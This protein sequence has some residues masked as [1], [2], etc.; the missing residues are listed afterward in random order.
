MRAHLTAALAVTLLATPAAASD[1]RTDIFFPEIAQ[2]TADAV[3]IT[4]SDET[5]GECKA[6]VSESRDVMELALR[7]AGVD[8]TDNTVFEVSIKVSAEPVPN[9]SPAALMNMGG[10]CRVQIV[11]LGTMVHTVDFMIS[12]E[13]IAGKF[14]YY[15]VVEGGVVGSKDIRTYVRDKTSAVSEDYVRKYQNAKVR[16]EG[17]FTDKLGHFGSFVSSIQSVF[18][19][20]K[21][22]RP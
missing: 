8:V 3:S 6:R 15:M 14:P 2:G 10:M 4:T 7:R 18:Q 22:P 9:L 1:P 11:V 20:L 19:A 17:L 5:K 12:G 13:N 21:E 16:V